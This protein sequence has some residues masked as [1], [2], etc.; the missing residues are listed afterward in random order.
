MNIGTPVTI[1]VDYYFA[2]D[3]IQF[4]EEGNEIGRTDLNDEFLFDD[5]Y[6]V[7]TMV[8]ADTPVADMT[9]HVHPTGNTLMQNLIINLVR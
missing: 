8:E 7:Y 3:I 5:E 2:S 9:Y 4:D 6:Y 1:Q